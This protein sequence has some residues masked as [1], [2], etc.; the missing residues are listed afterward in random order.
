[1]GMDAVTELYTSHSLSARVAAEVRSQAARRGLRQ[2]DLA[3]LLEM[4][5]PQV[6]LRLRGKVPFRLEELDVLAQHFG[7]DAAELMPPRPQVADGADRLPRLDLNQQPFVYETSQVS[8]MCGEVGLY[9][10]VIPLH[11]I[12]PGDVIPHTFRPVILNFPNV[13]TA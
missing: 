4:S 7:I 6:S 5:Q 13:V 1:M 8:D 3:K 10:N 9:P 12:R 2:V 11:K